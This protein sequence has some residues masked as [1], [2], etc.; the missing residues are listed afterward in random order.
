MCL[1]GPTRLGK[2]ELRQRRFKRLSRLMKELRSRGMTYKSPG[3]SHELEGM[4]TARIRGKMARMACRRNPTTQEK[5]ARIEHPQLIERRA[6]PPACTKAAPSVLPPGGRGQATATASD[7]TGGVG[8]ALIPTRSGAHQRSA[9]HPRLQTIVADPWGGS[10]AQPDLG[11]TSDRPIHSPRR[12][13]PPPLF[14]SDS[15]S[16]VARPQAFGSCC[17]MPIGAGGAREW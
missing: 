10:P 16:T 12:P 13:P 14:L 4:R 3:T 11:S 17:W 5:S 8:R 1:K 2:M 9:H 7:S 15:R 6:P